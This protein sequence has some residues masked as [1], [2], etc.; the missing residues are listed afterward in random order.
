MAGARAESGESG[1]EGEEGEPDKPESDA[2]DAEAD[3]AEADLG[4]DN[5]DKPELDVVMNA[6]LGDADFCA[7]RAQLFVHSEGFE[8]L[9]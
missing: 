4:S 6:S 9:S 8:S 2:G 1:A 7:S 3:D 5:G